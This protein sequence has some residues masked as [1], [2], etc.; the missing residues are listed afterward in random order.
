MPR[1]RLRIF[2]CLCLLV[3]ILSGCAG[4]A[5]EER[6]D[7]PASYQEELHSYLEQLDDA[8]FGGC[9]YAANGD[10]VL[11]V[12]DIDLT[13]EIEQFVQ[14]LNT[15]LEQEAG[16]R[17][18]LKTQRVKYS[19]QQLL[20]TYHRLGP[21]IDQGEI[22]SVGVLTPNNCVMVGVRK[23]TEEVR[24]RVYEIAEEDQVEFEIVSAE[25]ELH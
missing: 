2:L 5:Y 11:Y 19:Y 4:T 17:S 13:E 22:V 16:V 1:A 25:I 15:K 20:D 14:E 18:R 7:F 12:L 10:F 24:H 23:L 8:D 21:L 3:L 6:N 9:A